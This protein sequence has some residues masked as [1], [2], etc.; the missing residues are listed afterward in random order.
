[1]IAIGLCLTLILGLSISRRARGLRRLA[2]AMAAHRA[3]IE[4]V[5]RKLV[6]LMFE[7]RHYFREVSCPPERTEGC[8]LLRLRPNSGGHALLT[9]LIGNEGAHYAIHIEGIEGVNAVFPPEGTSCDESWFRRRMEQ[10]FERFGPPDQHEKNGRRTDF[11]SVHD[12]GRS[13]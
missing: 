4:R 8:T 10:L 2:Q 11:S 6:I 3:D 1:M 13:T 7:G 12:H 5:L 9:R